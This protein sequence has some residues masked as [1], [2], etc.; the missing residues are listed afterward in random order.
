MEKSETRRRDLSSTVEE[1]MLICDT[2]EKEL[3]KLVSVEQV[4][5]SRGP[6]H[7]ERSC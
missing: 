7:Q 3:N 1:L 4:S 2:S 5:H 6:R